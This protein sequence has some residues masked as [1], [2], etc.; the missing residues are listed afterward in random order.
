MSF[1]NERA[2]RVRTQDDNNVGWP[3][4]VLSGKLCG[5]HGRSLARLYGVWRALKLRGLRW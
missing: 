4:A 5:A 1:L 2:T 3:L